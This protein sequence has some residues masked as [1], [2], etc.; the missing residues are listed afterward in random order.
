MPLTKKRRN[1]LWYL[2]VALMI[3]AYQAP[4]FLF[5]FSV[6]AFLISFSAIAVITVAF[7]V[8]MRR[9]SR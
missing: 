2:Y 5:D 7:I 9:L 8:M 1:R 3:V 4:M 6:T